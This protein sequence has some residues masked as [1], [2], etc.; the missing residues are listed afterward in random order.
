MTP[1]GEAPRAT[2]GCGHGHFAFLLGVG[3]E[4][5]G[6]AQHA[7]EE[8]VGNQRRSAVLDQDTQEH[9]QELGRC[10]K[11]KQDTRKTFYVHYSL[12]KG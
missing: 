3:R 11:I 2:N 9:G 8:K 6:C 12:M 5:M 7:Q 4:D 10:T 1:L